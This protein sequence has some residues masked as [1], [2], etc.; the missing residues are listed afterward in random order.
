MRYAQYNII[1]TSQANRHST[2]YAQPEGDPY[3]CK[4]MEK[5]MNQFLENKLQTLYL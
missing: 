4:N 5:Q 2:T 1:G 3:D